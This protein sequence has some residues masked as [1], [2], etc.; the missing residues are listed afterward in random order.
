[1]AEFR[2][3]VR[4]VFAKPGT[5]RNGK[6]YTLY[7]FKM[8]TPEGQ[9]LPQ[10]FQLGF[11][12]PNVKADWDGEKY[13]NG[14]SY[15]KF[16]GEANGDKAVKVDESSLKRLKNPPARQAVQAPQGGGGGKGGYGNRGGGGKAKEP[17]KSEDRKSVV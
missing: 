5:G 15:V 9:E 7:S 13:G 12:E 11:N 8:A 1:M 2:G 16:D 14:G 6:P 10:W 3:F 17:T 4:R